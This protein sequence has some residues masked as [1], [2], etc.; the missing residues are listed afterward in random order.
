MYWK[1]SVTMED[2]LGKVFKEVIET[3]DSVIFRAEDG[4][5][6]VMAHSQDCCEHVYV[7]SIV[8]D[9][10]DLVG[11]PILQANENTSNENPLREW[12]E[13]FTWTF[14]SFRTIKGSVDI[15][16]YGCS[17]GYYSERV[18]IYRNDP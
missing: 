13:S 15:R 12:E 6:F 14:Y 2:F 4:T 17:N 5:E 8:G 3:E 16:W 10:S 9:L 7:E 11:T 18:D 1:P